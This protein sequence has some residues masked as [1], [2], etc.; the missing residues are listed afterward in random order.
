VLRTK[1]LITVLLDGLKMFLGV[2]VTSR[3]SSKSKMTGEAIYIAHKLEVAVCSHWGN[4]CVSTGLT[5]A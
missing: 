1:D 2:S 5:G 4:L 3:N